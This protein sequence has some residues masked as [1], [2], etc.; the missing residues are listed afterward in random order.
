MQ[1]KRVHTLFRLFCSSHKHFSAG[2]CQIQFFVATSNINSQR[3]N[4]AW[5]P[6]LLA[7]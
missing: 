7:S 1:F 6:L 2:I 5:I 4:N 3:A